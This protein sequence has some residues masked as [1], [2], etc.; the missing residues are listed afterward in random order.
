M[1]QSD[2]FTYSDDA[3]KSIERN[4]F[5]PLNYDKDEFDLE[6]IKNNTIVRRLTPNECLRLMGF[7]TTKFKTI[8]SDSQTYKQCGNSI[9]VN[10]FT[11]ILNAMHIP[12]IIS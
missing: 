11:Q 9:V 1:K 4:K 5:I 7:D 10:M 3:V 8:V 2:D 6:Y 12:S